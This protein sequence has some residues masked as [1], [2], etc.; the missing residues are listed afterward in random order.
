MATA[1]ASPAPARRTAVYVDGFNLYYGC[2]KGTPYKWL[3]LGRLCSLLLPGDQI[4][5]LKYFTAEIHSRPDDPDAPTRQRLYLRALRTIPNLVIVLGHFRSSVVSLPLADPRGGERR[6]VRVRRYEEKGSDVN[7]A[8][9]LVH[10]AHRG[11]FDTA[12]IVSNDSD[13]SEAMRIVRQELDCHVGLLNPHRH[14]SVV[15]RQHAS[16]YKA[17]RRG[18]LKAS[19]FPRVLEDADGRFSRPR[20]W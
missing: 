15:L 7:L 10:D 4:V 3:D 6:F 18:A 1:S 20:G 13:L 11:A 2:V 17:I 8:T 16:F 5:Y 19:Q 14:P 12:A 9:H